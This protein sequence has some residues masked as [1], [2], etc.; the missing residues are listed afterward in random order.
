M[1][2]NDAR[3]EMELGGAACAQLEQGQLLSPSSGTK[4]QMTPEIK[5]YIVGF[6]LAWAT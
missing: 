5:G 4:Q 2:V 6:G 1:S 3:L